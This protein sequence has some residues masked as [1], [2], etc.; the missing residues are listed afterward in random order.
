[1]AE[2]CDNCGKKVSTWTARSDKANTIFCT[3]CF[4]TDE[5]KKIIE[6]KLGKIEEVVPT[7][8]SYQ[9][10]HERR[11]KQIILTTESN[12]IDLHISKRLGV[13]A[14]E[15]VLGI[16]VFKDLM[17]GFRDLVGGESG[18]ATQSLRDL[19]NIVLTRL[20]EEALELGADAVIA[21]SLNYNEFSGGGKSMLFLVASG[22]AITLRN[23][24]VV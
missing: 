16:N 21:I 18:T 19:R 3:N 9:K 4:Q 7:N 20:Q 5:A 24:R 12:P 13:I 6:H 15:S 11:L 1:M 10:E 23:D 8:S 17:A 2:F 22:T 14:A